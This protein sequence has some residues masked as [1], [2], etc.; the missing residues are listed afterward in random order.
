[1][2]FNTSP[3][4]KTPLWSEDDWEYMND[5]SEIGSNFVS[6]PAWVDEQVKVRVRKPVHKP[7]Q[8]PMPSATQDMKRV[9]AKVKEQIKY[10]T[11]KDVEWFWVH[12]SIMLLRVNITLDQIDVEQYYASNTDG[13]VCRVVRD[14]ND[15][16]HPADAAKTTAQKIVLFFAQQK[17]TEV[18]DEK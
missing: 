5:N 3:Y 11:E 16:S 18:N 13:Q 15:T 6:Y 9:A 2:E 17:L 8:E 12:L 1:M 10:D 4:Y 7:V 14:T